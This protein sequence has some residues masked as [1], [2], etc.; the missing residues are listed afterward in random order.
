MLNMQ[1][2]LAFIEIK[3]QGFRH[4]SVIKCPTLWPRITYCADS[5]TTLIGTFYFLDLP[6]CI[7][8]R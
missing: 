7:A 1:K 5:S 4:L 8:I 3:K 2:V 6:Y